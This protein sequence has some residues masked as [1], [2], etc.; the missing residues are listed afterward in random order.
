VTAAPLLVCV[1]GLGL[2]EDAWAPTIV[3]LGNQEAVVQALPG[4]GRRPTR[5]DDLAPGALG[6]RVAAGLAAVDGPAVLLGHSASCQVVVHAAALVPHR[7]VGV[8]L[9]GP[10]TDQRAASWP[11]LVARWLRTAAWEPPWQVPLLARSYRRTGLGWM[12]RAMD[13]ARRDDLQVPLATLDCPVLVVRGRHDRICPD[14]W[15]RALVAVAP[16]GSRA[17]TL[18]LGAHMVPLTRGELLADAVQEF[19]P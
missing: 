13:A 10:T 4:Y 6:A 9:V 16:P 2:E 14:D 12:S 7:V 18:T 5:D 8:V 19:L 1:P 17:V 11:R 3:A 15:A